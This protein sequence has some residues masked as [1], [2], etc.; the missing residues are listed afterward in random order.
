MLFLCSFTAVCLKQWSQRWIFLQEC[1]R[2]REACAGRA[3]FY[4][5]ESSESDWL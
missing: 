3:C 5:P 2:K 4:W 1:C